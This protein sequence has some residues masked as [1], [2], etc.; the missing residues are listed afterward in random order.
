VPAAAGTQIDAFDHIACVIGDEQS[1]ANDLSSFSA[2]L[3]ALHAAQRRAGPRALV[4][5]D[6]IGNG[7][8]PGAGAALAQA[9]IET[10]LAVGAR[11]IV[12]TH[13]TQLK[14]FAASRERVAN[15][16]MLFDG[17][18]HQ[19]TYVLAMGVP[20]QSLAFA[21]AR[22]LG[23]DAR[24]VERAE[25]LLGADAQNLERAFESLATERERLRNQAADADRELARLH[26]VEADLREQAAASEQA[27]ARF[28]KQAAQALERAVDAVR[29]ELVAKAERSEHD[30][31]RQR[32]RS[33]GDTSA[34]LEKTM[35]EIRQS[36]GLSQSSEVQP[37]PNAFAVGDRVYVRSFGQSG[38]VSEIYDRD[39]LVTM[40][41]VKAVVSRNDLTQDR[42]GPG[43]A[44]FSRPSQ[45]R[46]MHSLDAS[47]SVD[48]RGMRVDEA[49]PVVDKALDDASLA[50]LAVLR[51]I[52]GKGTG[53]LGRG[54]RE[55]L[56]D[57]AQVKSAD[58]AP[59]REGGSGVTVVM[60]R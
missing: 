32:A 18:T 11:V 44:G 36:L 35:T 41:S 12:T 7:T 24:M 52:H 28:E 19:P 14:I 20:G 13:F 8:E 42:S 40:G 31:R 25:E 27:R 53:Q 59:D 60:L 43:A 58:V 23:L 39:V 5:V 55:F 6:E 51:I 2:H 57:H 22:T 15:A 3:R 1:I 26:A 34:A 38:M 56:R 54:I 10:L 30:A 33:L 50:G 49:M 16:S 37:A 29:Q 46:P 45:D 4:L 47:T 48:V 21:L 17:A 9:F